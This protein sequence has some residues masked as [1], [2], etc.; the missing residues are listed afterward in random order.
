MFPDIK[1]VLGGILLAVILMAATG[2]G[3]VTPQTYTRIGEMPV[4]GRPMVQEAL[5]G[6]AG[7]AQFHILTLSRRTTELARLRDL[8]ARDL[9]PDSAPA[10]GDGETSTTTTPAVAESSDGDATSGPMIASVEND[11]MPA[12]SAAQPA[13]QE[14]PIAPPAGAEGV[15][16]Q[17]DTP[18]PQAT[19][20]TDPADDIDPVAVAASPDRQPEQA[21]SSNAP[22]ITQVKLP[23]ARPTPG[24]A[25]STA[26]RWPRSLHPARRLA[27]VSP[28]D[29]TAGLFGSPTPQPH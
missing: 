7:E 6:Q 22:A 14:A 10:P 28:V 23:R 26:R 3:M 21:E 9:T 4:V 20:T 24:I 19:V 16:A 1:I 12:A 13:V 15:R 2:S 17:D 8:A 5:P 27:R 18:P 25:G 11:P 29:S